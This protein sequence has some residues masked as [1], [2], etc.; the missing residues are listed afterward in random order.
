MSELAL[1]LPLSGLHLVEASAGTGKTFALTAWILRLLLER[2]LSVVA[3]LGRGIFGPNV[4]NTSAIVVSAPQP[5]GGN[6]VLG[7]LTAQPL[8]LRKTTIEQLADSPWN[9]FADRTEA[10]PHATF[11]VGSGAAGDVLLKARKAA[12][13]LL[14]AL[15]DGIQRGVTPDAVAAHVLSASAARA[16]AISCSV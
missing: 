10:D 4:L 14:D 7:D 6:V 1:R 16:A 11:F 12:G 8:P 2:G 5:D 3:N 9:S 13:T 15:E